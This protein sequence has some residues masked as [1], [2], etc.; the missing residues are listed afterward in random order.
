VQLG[1]EGVGIAPPLLTQFTVNVVVDRYT[2]R[3]FNIKLRQVPYSYK[4]DVC[5]LY[6]NRRSQ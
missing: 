6:W 5:T 2:A 1:F 3:K 4:G